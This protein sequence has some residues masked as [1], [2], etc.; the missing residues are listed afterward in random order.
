MTAA[1]EFGLETVV[2]VKDEASLQASFFWPT[3]AS[4]PSTVF[5]SVAC[6]LEV[7][8]ALARQMPGR[9]RAESSQTS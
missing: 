4:C 2:E 8:R 1:D 3:R 6:R 5:S 9:K 7:F